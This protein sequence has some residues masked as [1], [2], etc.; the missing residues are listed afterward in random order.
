MSLPRRGRPRQSDV[1]ERIRAALRVVGDPTALERSSLAKRPIVQQLASTEFRGR[2]CAEGLALA[3]VLRHALAQIARDLDGVPVARLAAALHDGRSQ[4]EA[5][6]ELGIS[7]EY[8]CRRWKPVL[9][10]LV[11]ERLDAL[12]TR[13]V[14]LVTAAMEPTAQGDR[15][16]ATAVRQTAPVTGGSR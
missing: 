8:L 11:R 1:D 13:A 4:T 16:A 15:P 7:D 6:E 12:D 10:T 2:T 14:A 3:R 9:I 5:A